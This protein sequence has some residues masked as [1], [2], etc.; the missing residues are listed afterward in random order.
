MLASRL[1][2]SICLMVLLTSVARTEQRR[3]EVRSGKAEL[4]RVAHRLGVSEQRVR[5]GREALERATGLVAKVAGEQT[6]Y[7]LGEAWQR[8]HPDKAAEGIRTVFNQLLLEARK[9]PGG[10][11]FA[12]M[13]NDAGS[14]ALILQ[15]L[16]DED[17]DRLMDQWPE[18]SQDA[19]FE[20]SP[21]PHSP[22]QM[23]SRYRRLMDVAQEDP[24]AALDLLSQIEQGAPDAGLRG[25]MIWSFAQSGNHDQAL[26]LFNDLLGSG[27]SWST[28]S[29]GG[30]EL[31]VHYASE[32]VPE[33]L[34]E[35][36]TIWI[37]QLRQS[38]LADRPVSGLVDDIELTQA[39][40]RVLNV[41]SNLTRAGTPPQAVLTMMPQL[42]VK[43][44]RMGGLAGFQR[45]VSKSRRAKRDET[46]R[47]QLALARDPEQLLDDRVE[48]DQDLV[49]QMQ[50]VHVAA[51][52]A[53]EAEEY[54]NARR[55]LEVAL[56][57]L[58]RLEDPQ[59][60][61]RFY[62]QIARTMMRFDG[63]LSGPF[64]ARGWTLLDDVDKATGDPEALV[65]WTGEKGVLAASVVADFE[66][67]LYAAWAWSDFKD[68]MAQIRKLDEPTQFA[69]CAKLAEWLGGTHLNLNRH[70]Q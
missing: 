46:G 16:G 37:E 9:D 33:R 32:Y 38:P 36:L 44:E 62:R 60:G 63:E 58:D 35:A 1:I 12:M 31:A 30:L 52:R 70:F 69:V 28:K 6:V 15:R 5:E 42:A 59:M 13:A 22:G 27:G 3:V 49:E 26:E 40:M 54:K 53:F 66:V 41:V 65:E 55:T 7:L 57:F 25:S 43:L 20:G 24:E 39:E 67:W 51:S 4:R 21:Q 56:R 23:Y 14:L 2:Y 18:P 47:E 17:A 11:Q 68:A 29:E 50:R 45:A 34:P 64:L 10:Q 61:L 48:T 8:L 19:V